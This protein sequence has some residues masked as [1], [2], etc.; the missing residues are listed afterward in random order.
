[1]FLLKKKN[2]MGQSIIITS[3]H[4]LYIC[5]YS[6]YVFLLKNLF[7]LRDLFCYLP[8]IIPCL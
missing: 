3:V 5:L 1:M 2:K 7:E 8:Y 4:V 6:Y